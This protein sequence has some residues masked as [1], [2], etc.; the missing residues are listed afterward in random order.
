[1][2]T[3]YPHA[4]SIQLTPPRQWE[5]CPAVFDPQF[6]EPVFAQAPASPARA[7]PGALPPCDPVTDTWHDFPMGGFYVY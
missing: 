2:L 1:M 4:L 3:S 6:P 5:S 7:P